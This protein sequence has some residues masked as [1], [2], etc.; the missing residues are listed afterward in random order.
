ML[1]VSPFPV[2]VANEGFFGGSPVEN[3]KKVV[4]GDWEGAKPGQVLSC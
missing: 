3:D 1:S 2:S 4:V